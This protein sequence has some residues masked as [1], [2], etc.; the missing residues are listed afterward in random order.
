ML[1]SLAHDYRIANDEKGFW[2]MSE[3]DIGAPLTPG[4]AALLNAKLSPLIASHMMITGSRLNAKAMQ[5]YGVVWGTAKGEAAVLEESIKVGVQ[6]GVKAKPVMREI[7][8]DLW[9]NAAKQLR[10]GSAARA[11]L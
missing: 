7:K 10:D 8:E 11:H 4:F 6:F 5:Q 3:I 9:W 1:L 2:C